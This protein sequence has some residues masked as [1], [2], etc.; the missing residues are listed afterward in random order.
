M[1]EPCSLSCSRN[2]CEC[3][4]LQTPSFRNWKKLARIFYMFFFEQYH[5]NLSG[6]KGQAC[7]RE[8]L[9]CGLVRTLWSYVPIPTS[10]QVLPPFLDIKSPK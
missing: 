9:A 1:P 3:P 6:S 2:L 5:C 4:L 8:R 10:F 7:C